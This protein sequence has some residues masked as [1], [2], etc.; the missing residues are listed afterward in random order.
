MV[1]VLREV[2]S[3]SGRVPLVEGEKMFLP[4]PRICHE[5]ALEGFLVEVGDDGLGD[6]YPTPFDCGVRFVDP[7]RLA[8]L[9]EFEQIQKCYDVQVHGVLV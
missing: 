1:W 6:L 5:G 9:A 4:A 8:D 3:S 2:Q 7:Y